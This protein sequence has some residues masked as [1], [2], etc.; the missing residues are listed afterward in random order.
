MSQN[1]LIFSHTSAKIISIRILTE[2]MFLMAELKNKIVLTPV[3][4]KLTVLIINEASS[5]ICLSRFLRM[6]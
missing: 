1:F 5:T 6:C 2:T 4:F 3:C